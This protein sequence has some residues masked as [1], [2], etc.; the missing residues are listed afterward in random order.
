M[1]FAIL[2][3]TPTIF[4]TLLNFDSCRKKIVVYNMLQSAIRVSRL[5][6]PFKCY[7]TAMQRQC[8]GIATALQPQCNGI[9]TAMLLYYIRLY[10]IR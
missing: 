6:K 4:F 5:D 1:L 9:A 10:K 2:E 8:N 3:I 7:A